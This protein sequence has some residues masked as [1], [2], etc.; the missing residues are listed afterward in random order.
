MFITY[1]ESIK[2][3]IRNGKR[4]VA[5]FWKINVLEMF[6]YIFTKSTFGMVEWVRIQRKLIY[7]NYKVQ[8]KVKPTQNIYEPPAKKVP[9]TTCIKT[10]S[11]LSRQRLGLRERQQLPC[12]LRCFSTNRSD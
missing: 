7:L 4:L 6:V 11:R 9:G 2:N 3:L 10:A 12:L 5:T 8:I 1:G